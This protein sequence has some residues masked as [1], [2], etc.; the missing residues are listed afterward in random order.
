MNP[1]VETVTVT[2]AASTVI[3][4]AAFNSTTLAAGEQVHIAARANPDGTYTAVRVLV[5]APEREA[6]E[7]PEADADD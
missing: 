2:I 6:D 4:A 7:T 5:Q 3:T 1:H